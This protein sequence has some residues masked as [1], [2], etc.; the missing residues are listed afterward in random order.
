[1]WAFRYGQCA[2]R[3][4]CGSWSMAIVRHRRIAVIDPKKASVL[5]PVITEANVLCIYTAE[6]MPTYARTPAVVDVKSAARQTSFQEWRFRYQ[7]HLLMLLQYALHIIAPL[8]VWAN[9]PNDTGVVQTSSTN[10]KYP[11]SPKNFYAEFRCIFIFYWIA[12]EK[13]DLKKVGQKVRIWFL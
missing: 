12:D 3:G 2:L 9:H 5:Y 1:V 13:S 7:T 4:M 11:A 10:C 6:P 8:C